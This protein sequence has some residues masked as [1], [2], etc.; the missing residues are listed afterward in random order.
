MTIGFMPL[1]AEAG[2][3]GHLAGSLDVAR[4]GMAAV[5]VQRVSDLW[6]GRLSHFPAGLAS[7]ERAGKPD[8]D[9]Q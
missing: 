7:I 9:A 3:K 1:L 6:H 5:G 8:T 2:F 4:A